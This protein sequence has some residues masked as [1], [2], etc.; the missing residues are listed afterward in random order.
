MVGN[1]TYH[2]PLRNVLV[3]L[4]V[5][6]GLLESSER[7]VRIHQTALHEHVAVTL[8]VIAGRAGRQRG[9]L[10]VEETSQTLRPCTAACVGIHWRDEAQ[11]IRT[12][13]HEMPTSKAHIQHMTHSSPYSTRDKAPSHPF[14]LG[15]RTMLFEV[16]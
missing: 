16:K 1:S 13:A 14:L 9:H 10:L 2:D 8:E 7:A 6:N 15:W 3:E 12:S 4:G 11:S 5:K